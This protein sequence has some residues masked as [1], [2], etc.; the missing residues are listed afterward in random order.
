MTPNTPDKQEQK[1]WHAISGEDALR[2]LQSKISGLDEN[3][4][5]KRL[6]E[7][8]QNVLTGRKKTPAFFILLHQFA[9]P[10][11]Y[12]LLVAAAVK[13]SIKGILDGSVILGVLLFMALVGF[14]QE[15]RAMKAM[16]A[17]LRM[18]SPKAKVRRNGQLREVAA[19][20]IVPGDILILEAGSSVPADARLIEAVNL[21]TNESAFTGESMPAGKSAANVSENATIADRKSVVYM[22]TNVTYGRAVAVV[23]NT[24]MSTEIGKIAGAMKDIKAEKTP[25]QKSIDTLGRYIIGIVLTSCAL[26]VAIGFFR[27]IPAI[28]LFMMAV[29][30]AVAAI[31]E[32][33]PAVVT[34]VL[35]IGMQLMAKRNAIIRKLVAVET[36]GSATVICSD[37][38][39][40]LTLNQMTVRGIFSEGRLAEVTGTGYEPK[41]E[42]KENEKTLKI[43][44]NGFLHHLLMAGA[45]CSDA[46]IKNDKDGYQI[47]GD[48]TEGALVVAAAKA[49]FDKEE[50]EKKYPRIA[51]IPFQSEQQYMATL[52][53]QDQSRIVYVKGSPEKVLS[54]CGHVLKDSRAVALTE[55]E[56]NAVFAANEKMAKEA[57][58]VIALAYAEHP[59]EGDALEES[60]FSGRLV[61]AGLAGM[62]DPPRDEAI[63]AVASCKDAGIKV[64]M[65]T[66]DNKITAESIA[67]Q[68]GINEGKAIGGTDLAKLSDDDLR[69]QIEDFSVFARI[70]PLH[71]LRIIDAFKSSGHIVAMTGDGVN[72]APALESA[73]IGIAMGITGT[74]VAKEAADMVLADD[75]FASIIT[76]VEEG[77]AIFNRLRSV[78]L[79]LLST[80]FGELL[81]LLSCVLFV[82]KAPLFPLQI[83]WINLV[84]GTLMAVPLGVEPK[85]GNELKQP[86]RHPKVGL[87]FPGLLWRVAFFSVFFTICSTLIFSWLVP[88]VEIEK[89]STIIFCGVVVFEWLIAFNCRSDQMSIFKLGFFRNRWL[90]GAVGAAVLLQ[91]LVV[92]APFMQSP[93][94]TVPLNG[95]DWAI[96][97]ISGMALFWVE[98]FRIRFFPKLF[99][100]GKFQPGENK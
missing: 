93:F 84:T 39:G 34:A 23:V 87:L 2:E 11:V 94:S 79:F 7:R 3:E 74:D 1:N 18:T 95:S 31:P 33:L 10:L 40:T 21:Q 19:K 69:A 28:D 25:L 88:R 97:L 56:K 30:A 45:L 71:K 77:R 16:E 37:K 14:V 55:D 90:L 44:T 99:N 59:G 58:R 83:L 78:L 65:V 32:G 80:G 72:D 86:P 70:E 4:A 13:F 24:G 48:P 57:M 60:H 96:V 26:I 43:E 67:R 54:L 91:L 42:F 49:G 63:K 8:G 53:R 47:L 20:E 35:A 89:A 98:T 41:G 27:Q 36:L 75:N 22:G 29:S 46:A 85:V 76:A 12:I 62:I 50:T 100:M 73:N 17:L 52:H 92:Y 38:T 82:G 6:S 51:E 61:L 9:S 64:V 66:G 81:I 68:L 15:M 5:A